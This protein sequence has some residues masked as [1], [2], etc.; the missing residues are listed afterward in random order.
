MSKA[1]KCDKCGKYFDKPECLIIGIAETYTI[2]GDMTE[3]ELN[4]CPECSSLF[5]EWFKGKV[6]E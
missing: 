2:C 3:Q 5:N 4:M 1:Y 6:K